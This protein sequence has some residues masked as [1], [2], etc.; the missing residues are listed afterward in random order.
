[1]TQKIDKS[2]DGM[3][4]IRTRGGGM[5][6]TDEPTELWRHPNLVDILLSAF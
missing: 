3:L 2:V 6:G 4:G 1:M 5:E